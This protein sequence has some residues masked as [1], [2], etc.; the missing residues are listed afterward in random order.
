[1]QENQVCGDGGCVHVFRDTGQREHLRKILKYCLLCSR[2]DPFVPFERSYLCKLMQ[3]YLLS[4]NLKL[5][6]VFR[7]W[8]YIPRILLAV[9]GFTKMPAH[10]VSALLTTYLSVCALKSKSLSSVRNFLE[11]TFAAENCI[12]SLQLNLNF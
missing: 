5:Q 2:P 11:L 6:K 1:M 10:L 9:V 8:N 4:E 7:K 12:F 3:F